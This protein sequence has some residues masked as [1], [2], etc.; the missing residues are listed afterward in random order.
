[1]VLVHGGYIVAEGEVDVSVDGRAAATLGPGEHFGE[2]AL[3]RDVPRTATV[4][5]RSDSSLLALDRDEF[6]SAVTGHPAS[7]E[8]ADA[9]VAARLPGQRLDLLVPPERAPLTIS[10]IFSGALI[11]LAEV[12]RQGTPAPSSVAP[13]ELAPN[14]LPDY[15]NY[16]ALHQVSFTIE[17]GIRGGLKEAKYL[18][19]MLPFD[20]LVAQGLAW[21]VNGNAGLSPEPLFS[22]PRGV[23]VAITV[24]NITRISHVLH[25]HGHAGRLIEIAGRPI[26]EPVWRDTFIARPLEPAKILFIADNPGRWLIASAIAEHFDSGLQAWFEVM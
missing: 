4:T 12:S 14:P 23:T 20:R 22:V 7:R 24:D 11:H 13:V 18:G 17:G 6:V 9:V 15:F 16:A 26:V 19:K 8:A 3:L 2:I 10:A 5:A 1:M 21:A 25:I